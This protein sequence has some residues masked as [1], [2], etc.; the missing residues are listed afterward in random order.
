MRAKSDSRVPFHIL[1]THLENGHVVFSVLVVFGRGPIIL[2]SA[3]I[4]ME[5][6]GG[7]IN[8]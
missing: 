5:K 3:W 2:L 8:F 4:K 7:N 6:L 1:L